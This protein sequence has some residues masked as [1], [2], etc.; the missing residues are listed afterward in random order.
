[1]QATWVSAMAVGCVLH[2]N[3]VEKILEL[4]SEPAGRTMA[5][6]PFLRQSY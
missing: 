2:P 6:R 1:M 4:V 5:L 3:E